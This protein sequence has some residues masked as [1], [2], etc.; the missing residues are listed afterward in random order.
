MKTLL[1]TVTIAAMFTL[2]GLV[3]VPHVAAHSSAP[4]IVKGRMDIFK[5]SQEPV[6]LIACLIVPAETDEIISHAS[7][8]REWAPAMPTAFPERS[9][10]APTVA[11]HAIWTDNASF[12]TATCNQV[13]APV[14]LIA[15]AKTD[16][17]G[18]LGDVF[19]AVAGTFQACHM[20]YR[21]F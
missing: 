12:V 1:S 3:T 19:E 15:A 16:D 20:I 9:S 7:A 2:F 11:V 14:K 17:L 21:Q 8:M 18:A 13:A 10:G 5:T 6:K 4:G